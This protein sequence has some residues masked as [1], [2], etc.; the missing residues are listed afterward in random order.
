MVLGRGA[1][2]SR[3]QVLIS[4]LDVMPTVLDAARISFPSGLAGRSVLPFAGGRTDSSRTTLVGENDR[5]H[6]GIWDTRFKLVDP[7]PQGAKPARQFYDRSSDPGETKPRG[8]L[9][10][11]MKKFSLGLDEHRDIEFR[12]ALRTRTQLEGKVSPTQNR[13]ECEQLK[14]LGYVAECH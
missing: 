9:Q 4:T 7:D 10:D 8:D 5:G 1:R 12:S 2:P 13:K 6:Q 3:S 11:E 14:A